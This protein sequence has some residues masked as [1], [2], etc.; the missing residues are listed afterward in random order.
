MQV[1]DVF[2]EPIEGLYA[3]GDCVSGLNAVAPDL[4]GIRIAGGFTLGRVAG[5]AAAGGTK[6]THPRPTM[7]GASLPSRVDTKIALVNVPRS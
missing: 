4:G 2:G 3:T 6:D 7:Q 5:R 1:I